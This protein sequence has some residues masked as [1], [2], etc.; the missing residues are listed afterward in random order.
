[1]RAHFFAIVPVA[2]AGAR[3]KQPTEGYGY[4]DDNEPV[5]HGS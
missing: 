1:V 4:R 3:H 2:T 5:L